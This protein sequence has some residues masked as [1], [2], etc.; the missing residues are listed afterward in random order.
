MDPFANLGIKSSSK[1]GSG[2]SLLERQQRQLEE[3]ARLA[4]E[5]QQANDADAAFWDSLGS[6]KPSQGTGSAKVIYYIHP[7]TA[8]FYLRARN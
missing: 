8:P 1:Q 2:Q 4:R 5:K 3:R 7:A 6:A